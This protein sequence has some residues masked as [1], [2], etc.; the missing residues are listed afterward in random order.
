MKRRSFIHSLSLAGLFPSFSSQHFNLKKTARQEVVK[1]DPIALCTWNFIEANAAAGKAL[2]EGNDA[3]TAAILAAQIE[4]ENPDNSTVGFGGAPDR[5]GQVTLDACV[6]NH[7]GN[8]GA[9]LAVEGV[10]HVAALARDVMEKTPHVMLSGKGAEDFARTLN[11]PSQPLLTETAK[12]NWEEWKKEAQ[13]QPIINIENHDTIGILCRD[14]N[15]NI[16]GACSTVDW[17]IK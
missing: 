5:D 13:Y 11:Y 14:K 2:K 9:V 6:M 8:C 7:Q 16:G 4:E 12:R 3:L 17:H 1:N 10:V 15:G